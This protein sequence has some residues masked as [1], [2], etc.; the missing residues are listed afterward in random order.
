VI[1]MKRTP[2]V[3]APEMIAFDT[4]LRVYD[5]TSVVFDDGRIVTIR[6]AWFDVQSHWETE[7]FLRS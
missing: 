1:I 4:L 6:C 2:P 3:A 7:K 5:D